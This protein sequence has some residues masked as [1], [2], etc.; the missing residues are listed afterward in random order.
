[1]YDLISELEAVRVDSM[2]MMAM[3][4]QCHSAVSREFGSASPRG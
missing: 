1:M 4:G 2:S 3:T